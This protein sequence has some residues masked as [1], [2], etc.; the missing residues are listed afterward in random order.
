MTPMPSCP[1]C[2]SN[3]R[4][5]ALDAPMLRGNRPIAVDDGSAWPFECQPCVLVFRGTDAEWV[6]MTNDRSAYLERR[7]KRQI[8]TE[9]KP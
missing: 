1:Q 5:V 9:V 7:K 3:E 4:V 6:R 2:A 8:P